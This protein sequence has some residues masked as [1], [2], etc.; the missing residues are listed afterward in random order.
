[1]KDTQTV[2]P[3]NQ[4]FLGYSWAILGRHARESVTLGQNFLPLL[5]AI[6][7]LEMYFWSFFPPIRSSGRW[8]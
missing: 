7:F 2:M 3:E 4:S 8:G 6:A 5:G 1:M